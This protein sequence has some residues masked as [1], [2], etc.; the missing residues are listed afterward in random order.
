MIVFAVATLTIAT[1]IV[2]RL[3]CS[4]ERWPAG[5]ATLIILILLSMVV[6]AIFLDVLGKYVARS[7][8]QIKRNQLTMVERFIDHNARTLVEPLHYASG[9]AMPSD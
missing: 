7:Y 3:V 6:N 2:L 8:R 5:F 1:Y 9:I 4:M